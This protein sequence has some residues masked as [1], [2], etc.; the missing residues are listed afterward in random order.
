MA[1]VSTIDRRRLA[2]SKPPGAVCPTVA[3]PVA[4]AVSVG[5]DTSVVESLFRSG[6]SWPTPFFR[7]SCAMH[8]V[9]WPEHATTSLAPLPR[10]AAP[11]FGLSC[12]GF[13]DGPLARATGAIGI[14][15]GEPTIIRLTLST[16]DPVGAAP[17][18]TTVVQLVA[19][20]ID[21]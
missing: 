8:G 4:V 12:R 1:D 15:N 2:P 7:L 5:Q 14:E 18:A 17:L 20:A 19:R 16:A 6:T 3:R 9:P 11:S 21:A 10:G 13:V